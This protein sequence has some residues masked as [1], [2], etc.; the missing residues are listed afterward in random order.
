[1]SEN[2]AVRS[3]ALT[4]AR[5]WLFVGLALLLVA[6]ANGHLVYVA[7]TSEPACV[8]SRAPRRRH[9]AARSI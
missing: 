7:I 5:L 8:D 9:G 3:P 4:K 1:M 6:I 2:I